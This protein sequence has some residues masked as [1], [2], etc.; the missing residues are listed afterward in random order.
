MSTD[1][2]SL[3]P[4]DLAF[5]R[6]PLHGFLTV[7]AGPLPPQPRPVWFE[8]TITGPIKSAALPMAFNRQPL[9]DNGLILV[10]DAG[11]VGRRMTQL[12]LAVPQGWSLIAVPRQ[13]VVRVHA[14]P[15]KGGARR[16]TPR[17]FN[18]QVLPLRLR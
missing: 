14:Q 18:G 5:L 12:G 11:A 13:R 6:R 3:T 17:R 1:A 8:A 2:S 7:A 4:E 15:R 10:G 9:Y 16:L